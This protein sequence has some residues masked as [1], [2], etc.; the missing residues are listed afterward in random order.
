[1]WKLKTSELLLP[2][3]VKSFGILNFQWSFIYACLCSKYWSFKKN[4]R[5]YADLPYFDSLHY[6]T[7]KKTPHWTMSHPMGCQGGTIRLLGGDGNI[8]YLDGDNGFTVVHIH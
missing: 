5:S 2:F 7:S 4:R 3:I 8:Q 6:I 1:M